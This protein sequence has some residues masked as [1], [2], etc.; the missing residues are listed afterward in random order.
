MTAPRLLLFVVAVALAGPAALA[1][2]AP[3]GAAPSRDAPPGAPARVAPQ[4]DADTCL[5]CHEGEMEGTFKDGTTRT[6]VVQ[7]ATLGGSAHK[8]LTCV[9]CHVDLQGMDGSH[10]SREF[11]SGR[12]LRAFFSEQC[13]QCHFS[14][15]TEAQDGVHTRHNA[16]GKLDG[17]TCVDCHGGHDIPAAATAPRSA[18]SKTCATCHQKAFDVYARSVHGAALLADENEDVPVC[19]DCHRSHDIA[20]PKAAAWKLNIPQM[21]GDCHGNAKTMEKYGL[22][23]NV[24]STYFDDFHGTTAVFQRSEKDAKPAVALCTDCHGVHDI[25]KVD[26]ASSSVVKANLQRTCE[27][28]HAGAAADFPD[29]WLSHYEPTFEKA[30]LV[31]GVKAFY[32]VLIPFMIGG[33]ALQIILHI[34]RTLVNR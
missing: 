13:K 6:M 5:S 26:A 22:S 2:G 28:C 12:E 7:P 15:Y 14:N 24:I 10:D 1:Q 21:C 19:T 29:A 20:D 18:I 3:P 4:P 33:L 31:W 27:R 11:T 8:S 16:R 25:Q 30:P 32:S 34:W 23:A 17:A 9:E